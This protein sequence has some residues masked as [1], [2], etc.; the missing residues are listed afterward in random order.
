[1]GTLEEKIVA[2]ETKLKQLK[3]EQ[4]KVEARKKA[5]EVKRKR[6]DDTR[7]KILAGAV[8]LDQMV[9]EKWPKATF[10]AMMDKALTRNEDRALF[11]LPAI[12]ETDIEEKAPEPKSENVP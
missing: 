9:D 8:L 1:M 12:S 6:Q 7:R 4:Q 3:A 2:A 11:E 10:T 5:V